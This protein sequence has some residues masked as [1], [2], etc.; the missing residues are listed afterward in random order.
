MSVFPETPWTVGHQ[1]PL[2][3]A[4]PRQEYWSGLSFLSPGDIPDPWMGLTSSAWQVNSLQLSHL[5]QHL[6]LKILGAGKSPDQIT[7]KFGI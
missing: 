2:S 3:M 5:G 7:S 4:F 6:F 1:S